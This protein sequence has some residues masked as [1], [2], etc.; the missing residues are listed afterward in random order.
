[1]CDDVV[2]YIIKIK[3]LSIHSKQLCEIEDFVETHLCKLSVCDTPIARI[4]GSPCRRP[5]QPRAG[6]RPGYPV[7]AEGGAG[8]LCTGLCVI[9]HILCVVLVLF[10]FFD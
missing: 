8:S 9:F 4:T 3:I 6:G 10:C 5:P 7:R 2:V 1:M